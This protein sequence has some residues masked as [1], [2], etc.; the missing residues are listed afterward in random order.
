[1]PRLTLLPGAAASGL[2]FGAKIGFPIGFWPIV[3]WAGF[4]ILPPGVHEAA[5]GF[6]FDFFGDEE[7]QEQLLL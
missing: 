6:N 3:L 1:M 4:L 5:V 7:R 2:K